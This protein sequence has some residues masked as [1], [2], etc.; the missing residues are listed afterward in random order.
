MSKVIM[1]G[2]VPQLVAPSS[3][4]A[5]FA[6]AT[7]EQIIEACQSGKVPDTWEVGDQKTMTINGTDYPIDI[8]GKNH[9][10]YADGNGTAPL[11]LQMHNC[12]NNTYQVNSSDTNVGGWTSCAIRKT[13]LPAILALM[14]QEVQSAIREVTKLTSAGNKSGTIVSTADKLF[15]LSEIE[16]FGSI[17]YAAEGEGAQYDYYK[18]GNS[19]IKTVN[20]IANRYSLRSPRLN[21]NWRWCTVENNGAHEF[22]PASNY[23]GVSFAFCF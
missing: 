22:Y 16:V 5:N 14:P 10:S 8:I 12:Y 17:V 3:Y 21:D 9:D 1:S 6:D 4:P 23:S 11:T 15:S 19:V 13:N 7:W 18:A 20:G 2:I